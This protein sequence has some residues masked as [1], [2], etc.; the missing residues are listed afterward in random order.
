MFSWSIPLSLILLT[1][2]VGFFAYLGNHSKERRFRK[3]LMQ[4][5][6]A[7]C[8]GCCSCIDQDE[9]TSVAWLKHVFSGTFDDYILITAGQKES[10]KLSWKSYQ[11]L[12]RKLSQMR[13]ELHMETEAE[14][15]RFLEAGVKGV[16]QIIAHH[17]FGHRLEFP[18]VNLRNDVIQLLNQVRQY[19]DMSDL[20]FLI[21]EK[22]V[23]KRLEILKCVHRDKRII[24][25]TLL[26]FSSF[27]AVSPKGFAHFGILE[28]NDNVFKVMA[29][30]RNCWKF[31]DRNTEEQWYRLL[32][33]QRA[34]LLGLDDVTPF[35]RLV[36]HLCAFLGLTKRK[37]GLLVKQVLRKMPDE[38][39]SLIYEEFEGIDGNIC[40]N[41][42]LQ[43]LLENLLMKSEFGL[44]LSDRLVYAVQVGLPFAAKAAQ[45]HKTNCSGFI[46]PNSLNF[47]PL[48][49]S[50]TA[51]KDRL[52]MHNVI[53]RE[54][55]SVVFR[56]E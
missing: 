9:L 14:W 23:V 50:I 38:D 10:V 53:V 47:L 19:G 8:Q 31:L 11:R 41:I 30:I 3:T 49:H 1:L 56:Q 13:E 37:D 17:Y 18:K 20:F 42:T 29:M 26:F 35:N 51:S 28:F 25:W 7:Y 54:S 27:I 45:M 21:T 34:N 16:H 52:D 32:L 15:D 4:S 24:D 5:S 2:S 44:T 43:F 22:D 46:E 33:H 40:C 36:T 39:L 48:I 55:G 6:K 12:H